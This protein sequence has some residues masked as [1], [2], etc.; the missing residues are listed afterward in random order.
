MKTWNA[1][2]GKTWQ[3]RQKFQTLNYLCQRDESILAQNHS[4]AVLKP[5]DLSLG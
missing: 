2:S 5:M 1:I 4:P 3:F